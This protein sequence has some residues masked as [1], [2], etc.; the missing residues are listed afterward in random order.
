LQ[1]L[2]TD[3][4]KTTLRIVSVPPAIQKER[5]FVLIQPP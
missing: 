3:Q 1:R 4:A 5:P 2:S